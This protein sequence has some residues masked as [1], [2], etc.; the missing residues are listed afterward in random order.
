MI[1]D[2]IAGNPC[3][4]FCTSCRR[5]RRDVKRPSTLCSVCMDNFY[6]RH[7]VRH[8]DCTPMYY[9]RKPPQKMV[10]SQKTFLF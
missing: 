8:E 5:F 10:S 2:S 6:Q 7:N 1:C 3:I 9:L 4:H